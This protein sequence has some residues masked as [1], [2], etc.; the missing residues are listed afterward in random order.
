MRFYADLHLHSKYSRATSRDCDL[1][2]LSLWARRKGISVIGTGDFTHPIWRGELREKL[3]PAEPGLFRLKPDIERGLQMQ[4]GPG[5]G[6][7]T[8]FMLEVEISTIYKKGER[9][10]KVHHLVYVPDF[11]SVDRLVAALSKIGNLKSDGRPILGLDSRHL[12]EMTLDSGEGAYLVP[13]H[14]WTPWFAVLGSKSGFDAIEECYGDLSEQIFA[15]ETGLSSD[16]PMNWRLSALD[17]F[18]LVSNSDAHSPPKLGREAC[19]FDCAMDYFAMR[20]ALQTRQGFA[21]T[22]EFFPEEG[23]YHLDGHRSCGVRL[24]PSQTRAADGRCPDCGKPVTVG[25]MHRIEELADR[26]VGGKPKDVDPYRSLLPLDEVLG[27]LQGV[28]AKSKR[29]ARAYQGVTNRVGPELFVLEEAPIDQ[30]ERQTTAVLAEA[31]A[32]MRRGQV[33]CQAGYDGEYGVIKL[34]EP[35]ELKSVRGERELFASP[36][37]GAPVQGRPVGRDKQVDNLS[38]GNR[39]LAGSDKVDS[40]TTPRRDDTAEVNRAEDPLAGLDP[41]QRSAAQVVDRPLLI[42]AGPGTGKTR[43][44]THRIAHLV[45]S[46][47]AKPQSIVA[48]TFTR[49]AAEELRQ[50]L[51]QLIQNNALAVSVTTF[52]GFAHAVLR[53]H[54]AAIGL[55]SG[56]Q[57]ADEATCIKLMCQ[58]CDL[59]TARAKQLLRARSTAEE[60]ARGENEKYLADYEAALRKAG[61]IPVNDLVDLACRALQADAALLRGYRQTIRWL[62]IDEYQDIDAVQ[63][64]LVQLLCGAVDGSDDP[65]PN[66]CAI[67]DPDQSIYSFRGA[68]PS[69]FLRFRQDYP[70]AECIELTRNYRS[71]RAIIDG[72]LQV[73]NAGADRPAQLQNRSLA[74]MRDSRLRIALHEAA[75]EAAEAEFVVH[76]IEGLIGGHNFFSLDS[77]RSHGEVTVTQSF[78]DFAILY[79]SESQ[80]GPLELALT[81]SGIPFR[82]RS[83]SQALEGQVV[84]W[85]AQRLE[86]DA[87]LPLAQRL[88]AIWPPPKGLGLDARRRD[89]LQGWLMDLAARYGGETAAFLGEL[90][91]TAD[92]DRWDPNAEC[93]S[94]LTLHAS[95]GLEFSTVFIVGCEDGLFPLRFGRHDDAQLEEERRLMFVG[96]TRAK[97]QLLLSRARTRSFRGQRR[98]LPPSPFLAT[99]NRSLLEAQQGLPATNQRL[100]EKR[101]QLALF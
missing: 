77:G 101:R 5:A 26:P 88:T 90:A 7:A 75:S 99:I 31:I 10:R 42:L 74:T 47:R 79:R 12:L 48:I 35:S 100:S 67:G 86:A 61:L 24:D 18:T 81:R 78:A 2:H 71:E 17:R 65:A 30:I 95:K 25:V 50:R 60:A 9:T 94:L 87:E 28:G 23:K 52:H 40:P 56:W 73:I 82:R 16:P 44:L 38:R 46:G 14:I 98:Q 84:H 89:E 96:M 54:G 43:T 58:A 70:Q 63:Y 33:I 53:E 15:V 21:G 22:V 3:V 91:L 11:E 13:A 55:G 20:H 34:F 27:E 19:V 57:V 64:R 37:P 66:L 6:E 72:A 49:R 92:V 62:C 45:Q 97:H 76:G 29:V 68:D 36:M 83:H 1:E 85:L 51:D 80:A 4:L 59:P 69:F 8:R 32:R 39:S 41:A 93:V